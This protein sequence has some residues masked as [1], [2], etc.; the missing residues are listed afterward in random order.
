VATKLNQTPQTNYD[1]YKDM[2]AEDRMALY[3]KLTQ[4]QKS[5]GSLAAQGAGGLG[6]AISRSFGGQNT[7]YQQGI[8]ANQQAQKEGALGAMDTERQQKTQDVQMAIMGQKADP[9][10]PFSQ[11]FRQFLQQQGVKVPSGMSAAMLEPLFADI[12]KMYE[13]KTVAATAAGAQGVEAG[14]ALYGETLW[15]AFRNSIGMKGT[16]TGEAALEKAAGA[17]PVSNNNGWS[18]VK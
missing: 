5:P 9:N 7:N 1:F 10:S 12:G 13:A 4:Q 16:E 2:S 8:M 14:K 17:K 11:G 6:D 15:D 3:Q 18:V